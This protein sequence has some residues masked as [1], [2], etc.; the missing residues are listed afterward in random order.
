MIVFADTS[1]LFALLV[2]DDLMHVRARANFEYFV[3]DTT[4]FSRARMYSWRR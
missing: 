1:G 2:E 3:E 4:H